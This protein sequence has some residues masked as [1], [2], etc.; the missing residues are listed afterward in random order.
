MIVFPPHIPPEARE[1]L[2]AH[3]CAR[4]AASLIAK[5]SCQ[6]ST[7]DKR[8]GAAIATLSAT[9]LSPKTPWRPR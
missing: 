6:E 1:I 2:M 9:S 8:P 4:T 5:R 3:L 7:A